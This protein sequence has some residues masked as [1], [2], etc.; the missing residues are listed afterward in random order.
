MRP[1][2]RRVE[3]MHK[4]VRRALLREAQDAWPCLFWGSVLVRLWKDGLENVNQT[5]GLPM[6][7]P[8]SGHFRGVLGSPNLA[9]KLQIKRERLGNERTAVGCPAQP[10]RLFVFSRPVPTAA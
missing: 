2:M 10:L 8:D 7:D 9:V 5:L 4:C 6:E 3:K 1:A